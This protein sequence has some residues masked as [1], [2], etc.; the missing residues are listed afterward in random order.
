MADDDG[1]RATLSGLALRYTAL[2]TAVF[3]ACFG[4]GCAVMV[5][6]EGT[7]GTTLFKAG[8]IAAV[9]SLPLSF[10]L[11]RELRARIALTIE[12]QRAAGRARSDDDAERVAA[13]RARRSSDAVAD[14]LRADQTGP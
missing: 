14:A 5:P 6:L 7:S 13:A 10:V 12:A 4:I 11:G 1:D 3:G 2:R 8:L 9:I